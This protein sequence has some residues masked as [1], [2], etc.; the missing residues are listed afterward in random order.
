MEVESKMAELMPLHL[1]AGIHAALGDTT[2][3]AIVDELTLG[4][5]SPREVAD[6][7]DLPSNLLA[8]HLKVLEEAGVIARARSEGD[9][10]RTY[11]RLRPEALTGL[12]PRARWTAP[13]VVF[14]CTA[15]SARSQLAAALWTHRSR[16]PATSAGTQ[17]AGRVHRRAVHVAARHGLDIG[18]ATPRHITEVITDDDLVVAVCDNAYETARQRWLHWAVPDP[19]TADT[20]HAFETAFADIAARVERLAANVE[21]KERP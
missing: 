4:D 18:D 13:R 7:L 19:A 5:A 9:R 1:R 10:R 20:A 2:R 11:V 12:T 21:L 16:V 17:P 15:N 6:R 14:V 3:L 8:H